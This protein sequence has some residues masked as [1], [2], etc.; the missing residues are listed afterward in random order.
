MLLGLTMSQSL[1]GDGPSFSL[2]FC[3]VVF[4][5]PFWFQ[6][7]GMRWGPKGT[8]DCEEEEGE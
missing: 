5:L 7:T 2:G 1:D 8:V 6:V 4:C 3:S